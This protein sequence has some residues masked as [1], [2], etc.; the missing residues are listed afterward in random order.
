M[1][2]HTQTATRKDSQPAPK[3]NSTDQA[4]SKITKPAVALT[5]TNSTVSKGKETA[6]AKQKKE[7]KS[8]KKIEKYK[9]L[10]F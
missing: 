5:K 7:N 8:K 2:A 9:T 6:S 1:Q 4:H 3:I 10:K